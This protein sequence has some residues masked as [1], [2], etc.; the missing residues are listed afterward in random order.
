MVVKASDFYKVS[1]SLLCWRSYLG[2][3][4][5]VS[6]EEVKSFDDF[7]VKTMYDAYVPGQY[8][9]EEGYRKLIDAEVF[10]R[11]KKIGS[12]Q[13]YQFRFDTEI[14]EKNETLHFTKDDGYEEEEII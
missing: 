9:D 1:G 14:N 4:E 5:E 13:F 8:E 3:Y 11:G 10:F 7:R 6:H 2:G 12:T